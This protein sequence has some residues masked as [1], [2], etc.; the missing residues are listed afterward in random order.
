MSAHALPA[1]RHSPSLPGGCCDS[2]CGV[3]TKEP[4]TMVSP[5]S[6]SSVI[7]GSFCSTGSS[8]VNVRNRDVGRAKGRTQGCVPFEGKCLPHRQGEDICLDWVF[9][10]FPPR[11]ESHS[12]FLIGDLHEKL[13]SCTGILNVSQAL[14][15]HPLPSYPMSSPPLHSPLLP[16]APSCFL[17]SYVFS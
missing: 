17:V 1:G 7:W 9:L 10:T 12:P 3:I 15:L 13:N 16:E 14:Q 11:L 4:V 6:P 8:Y 5:S 2:Y